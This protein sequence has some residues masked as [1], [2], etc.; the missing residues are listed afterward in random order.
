MEK[1]EDSTALS[2]EMTTIDHYCDEYGIEPDTLKIDV[3]GYEL[4]LLIGAEATIRKHMPLI[5]IEIHR[6][7]LLRYDQSGSAVLK[8]L[9]DLNYDCIQPAEQR[10]V[11]DADVAAEQTL[12]IIAQPR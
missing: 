6:D 10:L 1:S 11:T 7:F 2:A 3:E 9:N 5:F 8:K 4:N 12:R